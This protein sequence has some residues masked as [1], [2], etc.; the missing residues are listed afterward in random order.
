MSL[1]NEYVHWKQLVKNEEKS[2]AKFEALD[3]TN[4]DEDQLSARERGIRMAKSSIEE[5][6]EIFEEIKEELQDF[7]DNGGEVSEITLREFK[8]E[9]H[10]F[11]DY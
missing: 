4:M 11:E 10:E 5:Y 2:L 1:E 9:T 3:T 8:E 6:S 7:I